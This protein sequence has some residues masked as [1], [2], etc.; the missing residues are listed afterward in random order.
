MDEKLTLNGLPAITP[1]FRSFEVGQSGFLTMRTRFINHINNQVRRFATQLRLVSA[2]LPPHNQKPRFPLTTKG[3]VS[4]DYHVLSE[5]NCGASVRQQ[6]YM[7]WLEVGSHVAYKPTSV[8]AKILVF[9]RNVCEL[10]NLFTGMRI[11]LTGAAGFIGSHVALEL[12]KSG[13]EIVCVD[14]FSNS[15]QDKDGNAISLKRV[16]Q[17]VGKDVPFMFADCC[18]QQQTEAVF[19]KFKIDGVVHLAGL[20]A[21]GESVEKPLEYYRN[22]LLATLLC[23]KYGVKNF[24]FSSSATVYGPPQHLPITEKDNV[25]CGITNPYGQT[26]YMIEQILIDLSKAEKDW[27]IILLRYFNPVGAHSSGLIGEDPKGIPNNLMP[28]VSQVAI[29]RLPYLTVYG[30]KFP[31]PDGTGVR[32]YIHVVDLARGHVAAFDRIKRIAHLGCEVYNL[33]TG[34]GYSVYEMVHALEKASGKK[35][36]TKVG[37]PRPGDVACVYCDPSLAAEKLGWKCEYG[38]NEMCAD[39]WNWQTKNPNGFLVES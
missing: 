24:V 9:K 12:L 23:R 15:V 37:V 20:K 3:H 1:H 31:T 33:G 29:G 25:G 21:V 16:S 5:G 30:D 28:F 22:N 17:I 18:N 7:G 27:N 4:C 14:N 32:D 26:K 6:S 10:V 38:L 35:I 19:Q 2:C 8:A 36:P 34:K 13:Y 39:L 11:L